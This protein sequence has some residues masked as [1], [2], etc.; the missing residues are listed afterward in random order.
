MKEIAE[1]E[2]FK[3]PRFNEIEKTL[4]ETYLVDEYIVVNR[5]I[6]DKL[7]EKYYTFLL[8]CIIY[9]QLLYMPRLTV[10]YEL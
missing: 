5:E 9:H 7:G 6:E 10:E 2:G 4:E 1:E 8:G 3:I